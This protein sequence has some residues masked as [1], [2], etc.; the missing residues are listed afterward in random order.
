MEKTQTP[1]TMGITINKK[2]I[3]IHH[4]YEG[5]IENSIPRITNWHHEVCQV[6]TMTDFSIPPSHS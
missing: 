1:Q 5:W 4:E 2:N 6:M 3:S